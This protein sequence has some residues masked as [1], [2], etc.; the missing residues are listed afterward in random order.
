MY[1]ITQFKPTLYI[2]L[3]LGITGFAIASESPGIWILGVGGVT[4]NAWLV[5][6]G[7]FRPLPRLL[8]NLITL[9]S[10]LLVARQL[11]QLSTSAVLIIGQ[12][13]VILQLVKLWEQRAN[14][15]Y[16]QLLVLSL[17]LMV[18][19][20]INTGSL[21]FGVL[22]V[23]Y[24][25][26]SLYCC[27][28]FHLKV[29]TD[30]AKAAFPLPEDKVSP[31]LLRQDQRHLAR[32]MR[33]LSAV[34]S[35]GSVATAVVVFLLFPR[36]QAQGMLAA[37]QLRLGQALTGFSDLVEFDQVAR[38]QQNDRVV[39]YVQATK[40]GRRLGAGD[41]LYLRGVAL[42]RYRS[43]ALDPSRDAAQSRYRGRGG[44]TREARDHSTLSAHRDV[45]TDILP[46]NPP[47]FG[48]ALRD[49]LATPRPATDTY[50]Q[51]TYLSPTGTKVLFVLSGTGAPGERV[52]T[53]RRI[54]PRRELTLVHGSDGALENED[55]LNAAVE[56]EVESNDAAG[57]LDVPPGPAAA[58]LPERV[59]DP[60]TGADVQGIK[61]NGP[62]SSPPFLRNFGYRPND[63]IVEVNGQPLAGPIGNRAID[64]AVG[65][66]TAGRP[67]T[68][69]RDGRVLTL[70]YVPPAIDQYARRPDVSGTDEQGRPLAGQ[71]NR[72]DPTPG[73]LDEE[74]A[75][76]IAHHL[77]TQFT[78]TLDVTDAKT[79]KDQDPIMWFLSEDGRRGHCEYFAGGMALLCQSLGLNARVAV[80][81]K[82]DEFN[83]FSDR[84]VVKQ[85]HAHA[86][87]EVLTPDGWKT[88]DPTSSRGAESSEYNYGLYQQARHFFNWLE[89]TYANNVIA[90]DNDSRENLIQAVESQ[91][92]RPLYAGVNEGWITRR[93]TDSKLY[94][95][96][97]D[98]GSTAVRWLT[99]A[100]ALAAAALAGRWFYRRWQLRRRAAR[101]GLDAL[102]EHE[103]LR[104]ARQLGFYD[105]LLRILERR[106]IA[107]A[108]H[109][110]PLEFA[111]G[112]LFLPTGTYETVRRL[113]EVFY[114]VRYGG[115]D[116]S[117]G[118]RRRLGRVIARLDEELGPAPAK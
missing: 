60:R 64:A 11:V 68:V 98:P 113:T 32:S 90:Y 78:Y 33:R 35:V 3:V 84:F 88:F 73:P 83:A 57:R 43:V 18:S 96:L 20:A 79:R 97:T 53:A 28:L 40:N 85:A 114:R 8:A 117:G 94:R 2:L 29:E 110:T 66:Y 45:A 86:W 103:R 37:P 111:R 25:F 91:M 41:T 46:G 36:G 51:S 65:S 38:I 31:A 72:L 9:G 4:L 23:A 13:L 12:F 75:T 82:C 17:L 67:V 116:L 56:Y 104:L 109:E 14:R 55:P 44:F 10:M 61:V 74:I 105:D 22:M 34:V 101:A 54:T 5:A 115:Q 59:V 108:E 48:S 21:L 24:L 62:V 50:T 100:V 42:D 99:A 27:L 58:P 106:R 7:R 87:V 89:F 95:M 118:L 77:R 107:R 49:L 16:A 63:V 93:I 47:R 69:V 30:K 6:T 92:T 112:L 71:R 15:D 39:A 1:N 76:S 70:P 80:G 102:P 19:A 26:V 52:A 81:F